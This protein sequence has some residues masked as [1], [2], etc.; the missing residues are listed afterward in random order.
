MDITT[1]QTIQSDPSAPHSLEQ[2]LQFETLLTDISTKFVNL[3]ANK[4]DIEIEEV[5]Q[6]ISEALNIDR[7]S[8]AQF[9]NDRKKLRVTHSFCSP[10]G[11]N[12]CR[13]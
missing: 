2:R 4:I 10:R 7:C 3:P 9:T 12:P 6:R 13:I 11:L 5:L 8:V 1:S